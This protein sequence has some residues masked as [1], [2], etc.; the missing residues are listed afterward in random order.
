[1]DTK[2]TKDLL[3]VKLLFILNIGQD[4]SMRGE[5]I[6]LRQA[7]SRINYHELRTQFTPKDLLPLLRMQPQIIDQWLM[8][9]ADKR[10]SSGWYIKESGEVGQVDNPKSSLY[11][12]SME[13]AV[14][15]YVVREL[16]F[17]DEEIL[18]HP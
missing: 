7:L 15:E 4:V 10:T 11:F 9:S 1:M 6:S 17:W 18:K 8:Y 14:A 16:D 5:G 12:A 3:Q 2:V 13:I